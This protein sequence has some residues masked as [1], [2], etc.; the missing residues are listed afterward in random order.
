MAAV[1]EQLLRTML[2]SE[3]ESDMLSPSAAA[4][5][6]GLS[7]LKSQVAL[8][9]G[10]L[11][12]T[13]DEE[14]A[15]NDDVKEEPSAE[16]GDDEEEGDEGEEACGC[17]EGCCDE[18]DPPAGDVQPDDDEGED[19][20]QDA[21]EGPVLTSKTSRRKRAKSVSAAKSSKRN[22]TGSSNR[23]KSLGARLEELSKPKAVAEAPPEEQAPVKIEKKKRSMRPSL[24]LKLR[25]TNLQEAQEAFFASGFSEAPKFTYAYSD[26]IVT[27]AF[28][29]NSTV[30][31]D[32]LPDAQ[33]IMDK[34]HEYGGPDEFMKIMYGEEKVSSDELRDLIADYLKEHNIED[35]V[36]IRVV[37]GML[38]AANVASLGE[39]RYAVNIAEGPVS[40][41]IIQSIADHEVGT[42]LLRMMND[43]HQVWHGF[44]D[45]Y[46][47]ANPWTTEEGFAT[48]NTYITLPSKLMYPQAIRY[49]AVCRGAQTGFVELFNELRSHVSDP[50]RCWQICCRIK[51]GMLDT[52]LP[53]AFYMDQ[54]YFKGAVEILKHL[55]EVDFGRLY[56]GQ[57]ALQDLDKVHFL[58]RKEVVKLPRFLNSSETLA[59][60]LA[61]CRALI[62]EN[63]IETASERVC[64][65]VYV[66]AGSEFFKKEEKKP[67][68][69]VTNLGMS[70]SKTLD[71]SRLEEMSRPR[72]FSSEKAAVT[73]TEGPEGSGSE[74][75]ARRPSDLARLA[76]LAVPRREKAQVSSGSE[77]PQVQQARTIDPSRLAE[78]ARPKQVDEDFL[79]PVRRQQQKRGSSAPVGERQSPAA[80]DLG[81]AEVREAALR[82]LSRPKVRMEVPPP[83]DVPT[84]YSRP[85]DKDRLALLAA[86]RKVCETDG[87]AP[88][89]CKPKKAKRKRRSKLRLLAMVQAKEEAAEEDEE[90]DAEGA[91]NAAEDE[92]TPE[93]A[94]VLQQSSEAL[95][96]TPLAQEG[97]EASASPRQE[98]GPDENRQVEAEPD[99]QQCDR[100]DQEHAVSEDA[101][102]RQ[103]VKAAVEPAPLEVSTSEAWLSKLPAAVP[104]ANVAPQLVPVASGTSLQ[105]RVLPRLAQIGASVLVAGTGTEESLSLMAAANKE[106]GTGYIGSSQGSA[107]RREKPRISLSHLRSDRAASKGFT[108]ASCRAAMPFQA[109]P[110]KTL[111][112][113]LGI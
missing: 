7:P 77:E 76:E 73:D 66:R 17:D 90:E 113:D 71:L 28:Q 42:H 112:L 31:F 53:G 50:K 107:A 34:V 59:T 98:P 67:A 2:E 3:L 26:E 11:R 58:L 36:E 44:R 96:E 104:A 35:K 52:S 49:W 105:R 51:R 14:D 18:E 65:R 109:V 108:D 60:Y 27:K 30:C 111:Q 39:G 101:S 48:L 62:K 103:D 94:L 29:D 1:E 46:R 23:S 102:P 74:Q 21:E 4:G 45:R 89:P 25:P 13:D 83:P 33:R 15:A 91:D 80:R 54:A 37:E 110:I 97:N 92:D 88:C 43:E 24:L 5:S 61:H 55:D 32:Y 99:V 8:F 100:Q 6:Q 41:P 95:P 72:N 87:G 81:S 93:P 82:E 106:M 40:K 19:A 86:P 56:G 38:S 10:S 16:E 9:A 68:A 70:A 79:G 47:L 78:L 63:M 64:K 75:G 57:I 12:T 84:G 22:S 69:K 20:R 85:V